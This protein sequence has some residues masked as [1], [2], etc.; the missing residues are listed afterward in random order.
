V[1]VF[2]VTLEP[3]G[4]GGSVRHICSSAVGGAAFIVFINLKTSM[5]GKVM[6]V[7]KMVAT[8]V[9]RAVEEVFVEFVVFSALGIAVKEAII[10][11]TSVLVFSET[12]RPLSWGLSCEF[13]AWVQV[14]QAH[15]DWFRRL[16]CVHLWF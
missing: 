1:I 6:V 10:M 13:S 3:Q 5:L 8:L 15:C 11:F 9:S 16:S 14:Y 2:L 12:L 4:H 7:R